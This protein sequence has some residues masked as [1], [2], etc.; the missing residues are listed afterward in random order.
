MMPYPPVMREGLGN[1]KAY[2]GVHRLQN[3][4][5]DVKL[6]F[7]VVDF[8]KETVVFLWHYKNDRMDYSINNK[9]GM[10]KMHEPYAVHH[11]RELWSHLIQTGYEQYE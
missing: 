11:M 3:I 7:E 10:F 5:E 9:F 1:F 8:E 2:K 6:T 4:K